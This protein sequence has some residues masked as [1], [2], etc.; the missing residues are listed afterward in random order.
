MYVPDQLRPPLF[1]KVVLWYAPRCAGREREGVAIADRLVL[2]REGEQLEQ[3]PVRDLP[4]DLG[5]PEPSSFC[6][7]KKLLPALSVFTGS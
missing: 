6:S 3:M 2:I 7:S 1:V 5:A 4:V